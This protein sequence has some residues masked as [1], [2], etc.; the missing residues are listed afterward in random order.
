MYYSLLA[1]AVSTNKYE[2]L[3]CR[4]NC[5]SFIGLCRG[6]LEKE[7]IFKNRV[8]KAVASLEEAG[9]GGPP[10]VSPFWGDTIL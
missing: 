10:R 2:R 6:D 7:R 3:I 8:I 1:Y 5:K 9:E 4:Q